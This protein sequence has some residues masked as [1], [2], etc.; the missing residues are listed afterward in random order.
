[1]IPSEW[2]WFIFGVFMGALVTSIFYSIT[3]AGIRRRLKRIESLLPPK[4]KG[5]PVK[6]RGQ[7]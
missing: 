3:N 1:M 2:T 7:D 5:T 4:A 6:I